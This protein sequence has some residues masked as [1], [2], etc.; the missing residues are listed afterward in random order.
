MARMINKYKKFVTQASPAIVFRNGR[1]TVID[2]HVAGKQ[3]YY[4]TTPEH[5]FIASNEKLFLGKKERFLL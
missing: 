5:G 1:K 4:Y 2:N 3:D